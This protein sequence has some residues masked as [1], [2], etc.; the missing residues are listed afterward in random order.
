MLKIP[1][2][3]RS[4]CKRELDCP[5]ARQCKERALQVQQESGEE[6]GR[7]IGGPVVDL[8]KCKRCGDCELACP[9]GAVKMV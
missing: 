3:D 7:A 2:V 1:W 4:K 8:E 9:E 6:E 5:A